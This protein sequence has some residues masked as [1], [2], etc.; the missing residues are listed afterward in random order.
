MAQTCDAVVQNAKEATLEGCAAPLGRYPTLA[1]T[2]NR[3]P[4]PQ[5][6]PSE[7]ARAPLGASSTTQT[8]RRLRG[9]LEATR[10]REAAQRNRIEQLEAELRLAASLE[11]NLRSKRPTVNG[12]TVHTLSRPADI[13]SGD[14]VDVV[15]L[16]KSQVAII[17][18][19]ATGHGL[20][21]GLL[22]AHLKGPLEH[23]HIIRGSGCGPQP[24]EALVHLN[25]HLLDFE[26]EECQFVTATYIIYNED[27][28][29]V[30]WARAGAPYPVLS[31]PGCQPRELVSNGALLGVLPDAAFEVVDLQ[32]GPGETFVIYTDG[33]DT[34][35]AGGRRAYGC[36]AVFPADLFYENQ[37]GGFT[38]LWSEFGKFVCSCKPVTD[39]RDDITV[40]ALHVDDGEAPGPGAFDT[41]KEAMLACAVG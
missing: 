8:I 13:V 35:L 9:A 29:V 17:L 1:T 11:R 25:K 19:D 23:F 22:A 14:M 5:T 20:A 39:M 18:L 37:A 31:R 15:R 33:L 26:L 36:R 40:V 32:L 2:S 16:N 24:D 4:D 7:P 38:D 6:C 3:R 34:L 41:E 27:T 21:A 10:K 28:H 30:Q 12:A